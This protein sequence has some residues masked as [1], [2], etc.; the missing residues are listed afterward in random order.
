MMGIKIQGYPTCYV[1]EYYILE[2]IPLVVEMLSMM[3]TT[4]FLDLSNVILWVIVLGTSR[5]FFIFNYD[6]CTIS[7]FVAAKSPS[8]EA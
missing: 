7:R 8:F 2:L 5:T 6:I 3:Q 4:T 1:L